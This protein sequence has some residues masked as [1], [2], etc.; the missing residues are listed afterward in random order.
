MSG[1][2]LIIDV[3][4]FVILTYM[5]PHHFFRTAGRR[6]TSAPVRSLGGSKRLALRWKPS[7]SHAGELS[8]SIAHSLKMEF[9]LRILSCDAILS[10]ASA[11]G[12]KG[13]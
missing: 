1:R 13:P 4:P 7:A 8:G 10:C 6:L 12:Q 5:H 9:I 11:L 2:V 3:I